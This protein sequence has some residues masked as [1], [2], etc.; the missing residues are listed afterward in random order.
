MRDHNGRTIPHATVEKG[1]MTLVKTLI[2]A[3][4]NVNVKERCG[5]TPPTLAVIKMDEEMCSFLINNF[6]V[7]SDFFFSTIPS[8]LCIAKQL[9]LKVATDMKE[10]LKSCN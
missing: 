9:K 10:K 8:P 3:G 4:M 7:Y 5:A 2:S 1:N 6:A